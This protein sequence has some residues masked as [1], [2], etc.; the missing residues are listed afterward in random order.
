MSSPSEGLS[1]GTWAFL[2]IF[3]LISWPNCC[4]WSECLCNLKFGKLHS[5]FLPGRKLQVCWETWLS[6]SYVMLCKT[7]PQGRLWQRWEVPCRQATGSKFPQLFPHPR[8]LPGLCPSVCPLQ[9]DSILNCL[10]SIGHKLGAHGV[11]M[12]S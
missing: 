4:L 9:N 2:S 6:K 5:T 7:G 1:Q 12:G 10:L 3:N 8:S 11:L